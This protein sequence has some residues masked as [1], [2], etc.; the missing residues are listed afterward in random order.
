MPQVEI[1]DQRK[2][3]ADIEQQ[4][5]AIENSTGAMSGKALAG[6]HARHKQLHRE[7]GRLLLQ[8]DRAERPH[9]YR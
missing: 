8:R 7:L 2:R 1:P 3:I 4:M 9:I 5:R 6:A